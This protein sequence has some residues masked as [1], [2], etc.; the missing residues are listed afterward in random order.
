M[1]E[2]IRVRTWATPLTIGAFMLMAVT[3]VMMFFEWDRSITTVVHQWFSWLFLA[4]A[5]G[6]IVANF[7][8]LK[9]HLK[10]GWGRT[11]V[12]AFGV[13]L[14]ASFF[15]WGLVTGPQMKRHI[16]QTLVDA[17]LSAL[18]DVTRTSEADLLRRMKEH[19]VDATGTQSIQQVSAQSG[20][21]EN[22]LLG[23]VFFTKSTN[24][25]SGAGR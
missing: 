19:G 10:S 14:I 8:P 4:G 7:R 20:V 2:P 12:I 25:R 1:A 5:A 3:G 11:S 18:A 23:I 17:P 13:V 16:E 21:G 24:A 6:H 9:G 22:Q 15:S